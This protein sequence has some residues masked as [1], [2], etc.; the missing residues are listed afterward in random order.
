MFILNHLKFRQK[1]MLLIGLLL[2]TILVIVGTQLVVNKAQDAITD[3]YNQRY[4]SYRLADELRQNSDDLTR[5]VRT[6][7]VTGDARWEQQYNEVVDIQSGK[8]P[9]PAGYE[10]IYWDFRA[11][12]LPIPGQPGE[13]IALL[14]MM[15]RAG[16]SATE[17]AKLHEAEQ[18]STGLIDTEVLAINLVK[19]L[20]PDGK[21]GLIQG[22]PDL[23][24]A[25]EL[26]HDTKY[27]QARA[28]IGKSISAF[29][30]LLD[31][32]TQDAID[33]AKARATRWEL[34]QAISAS[35]VFIIFF[36]ALY[37][38][39]SQV[40]TAMHRAIQVIENSD[41]TQDIRTDGRD[42][43]A[44]LLNTI[45]GL[46]KDL[47]EVVT[48]VRDRSNLVA[49]ASAQIAQG[50]QNLSARTESQASALEQTASSM[51]ELSAAVQQ[52]TDHAQQAN[53]LAQNA[54]EVATDGGQVVSEMVHT[55][56]DISDSSKQIA[57]IIS[58]ID[59]IAFQTNILALNAAVEAARA[60]EQ[61]RGFAVVA[62][63][64]R[65]LAGR[66]ADAAK[67]IKNLITDSVNHVETGSELV[68]RAGNAMEQVVSSIR[69]VTD[70]MSE[71]SSASIEQSSGVHQISEAVMQMDQATQQNAALVEEMASAAT[72]LQSDAEEL[73]QAVA[74]FNLSNSAEVAQPSKPKA[75]LMSST[76]A[77]AAKSTAPSSKRQ[78][79]EP[80][81]RSAHEQDW[82]TF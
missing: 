44:Q 37:S 47:S 23:V 65:T 74:M 69:K 77:R 43:V 50:N 19:G 42:E 71:I 82:D 73:V 1:L 33:A 46:L 81:V 31:R 26:L 78:D 9:R 8:V 14:D 79:A 18:K 72:S 7:V 66:S 3:A 59:S 16:F 28:E 6:Y 24:K 40:T 60:G 63:E 29:F 51:E 11:V 55:M 76:N 21:G 22:A 49:S 57:E 30:E 64:V 27:H 48:T 35:V 20:I 13:K 10:G 56:K 41:L 80:K 36:I 75:K 2:V 70:I 4:V 32:R 25:R 45:S 12:N 62:S 38:V 34:I 54:S 5:L 52:N 68:E 15:K 39:F 61:G 67:E 58:V 17:L 53:N